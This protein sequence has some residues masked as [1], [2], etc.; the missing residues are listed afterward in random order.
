VLVNHVKPL[1]QAH[2]GRRHAGRVIGK[3]DR[4]AR[5]SRAILRDEVVNEG[6]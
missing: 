6:G 1:H 3:H 4:C 2:Q 5:E